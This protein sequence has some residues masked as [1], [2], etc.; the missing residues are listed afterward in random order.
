M[1]SNKL[2]TSVPQKNE[3][4]ELEIDNLTVSHNN[5]IFSGNCFV[6]N[7][8]GEVDGQEHRILEGAWSVGCF[9]EN[10]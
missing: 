2:L 1:G 9:E 3:E 10:F 7:T 8:L 5:G 6:C 4:K